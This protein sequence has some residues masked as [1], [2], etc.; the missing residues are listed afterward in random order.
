[1]YRSCARGLHDHID[2]RSSKTT[3][4]LRMLPAWVTL[5]DLIILEHL[6]DRSR[7]H[8][9]RQIFSVKMLVTALSPSR[10]FGR[11]GKVLSVTTNNSKAPAS[12][13][14]FCA[15]TGSVRLG[16]HP[17]SVA[18]LRHVQAPAFCRADRAGGWR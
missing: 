18:E 15:G 7:T 17:G 8:K 14:F 10:F 11:V 2:F 6:V 16:L 1:M 4:C 5:P 13:G 3:S 12:S 9:N